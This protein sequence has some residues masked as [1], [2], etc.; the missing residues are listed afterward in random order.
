MDAQVSKG[1]FGDQTV[2][3]YDFDMGTDKLNAIGIDKLTILARRAPQPDTLLFLQ[4]AQLPDD[5]TY[6]PANPDKLTAAR[7]ELDARR[8]VA[9]QKFL[10]ALTGGHTA[11]QV[12]VVDPSPLGLG[13][14]PVSHSIRDLNTSHFKGNLPSSG[15]AGGGGTGGTGV[16]AAVAAALPAAVAARQRWW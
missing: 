12:A 8:A 5:L 16:A 1:H 13:A 7:E 15:G 9:V 6:D 3:N 10:L 2:W 11:F 14:L 4:T